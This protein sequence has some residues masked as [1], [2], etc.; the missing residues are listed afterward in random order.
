MSAQKE[1]RRSYADKIFKVL[2]KTISS[3][4]ERNHGTL[5]FSQTGEDGILNCFRPSQNLYIDVGAHS[6]LR[7]SNTHVLYRR[8]WR[9]IDIDPTTSS[10]ATFGKFRQRDANLEI[11]ISRK[12]MKHWL[13][14]FE[15][16]AFNIIDLKTAVGK[17]SG[18]KLESFDHFVV[19]EIAKPFQQEN[20]CN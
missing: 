6:P 7:Y 18:F 5:C 3:R 16:E 4:A 15:E 8:G 9:G 1:F 13:Y 11:A 19:N 14:E 20:L 10:M 2:D 17:K 12:K